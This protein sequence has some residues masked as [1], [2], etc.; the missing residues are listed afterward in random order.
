MTSLLFISILPKNSVHNWILQW[1]ILQVYYQFMEKLPNPEQPFPKA[2]QILIVMNV[3]SI[4]VWSEPTTNLYPNID[5]ICIRTCT[6]STSEPRLNLYPN[7][8]Q[9]YIRTWTKS[10]SEPGPNLHPNLDQINIRT[11]TKSI[12]KNLNMVSSV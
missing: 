5:Q 6:K 10:I 9:I 7:L 12:S 11:W 3:I 8:D 4:N 2:T 1:F